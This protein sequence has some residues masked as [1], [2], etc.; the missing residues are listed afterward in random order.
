MD[1]RT[2]TSST[3]ANTSSGLAA[4]T[5]PTELL[6][7]L[8]DGPLRRICP[9][10]HFGEAMLFITIATVLHALVI[11][12]P[13]DEEGQSMHLASEDVPMREAFLT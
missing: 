8:S 6:T 10:Y 5:S 9:G 12:L 11:E 2:K 1:D 13:K 7:L 3:H 4:G